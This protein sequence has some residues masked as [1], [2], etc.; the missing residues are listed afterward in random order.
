MVDL[1]QVKLSYQESELVGL[2]K[3]IPLGPHE[4]AVVRERAERLRDGI[5]KSRG[6]ELL[7]LI[8]AS[9]IFDSLCLPG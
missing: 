8:L 3:K 7:P 9:F 2:L 5:L 1:F 4:L 6:D